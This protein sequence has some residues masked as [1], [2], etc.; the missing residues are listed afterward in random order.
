MATGCNPLLFLLSEEV[1]LTEER[2]KEEI[3]RLEDRGEVTTTFRELS[4]K[5]Q[6]FVYIIGIAAS[7]FHIWVNTIGVMPAIYRNAVHLGF[8]MVLAFFFYPMFK[9]KP[10]K[11]FSIDFFLAL[12]ATAVVLYILFFEEEL[13][14]D[15][16][17]IPIMR[18]YIFAA[19]AIIIL[20][21]F[22]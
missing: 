18:D 7:L 8:I 5:W 17:S 22:Q 4:G 20:L 14:L 2:K 1:L 15:R 11:G 13:H 9:K 19:I 6:S 10:Q 12:L 16:A 3:E 21:I